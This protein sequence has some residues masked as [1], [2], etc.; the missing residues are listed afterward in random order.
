MISPSADRDP[1]LSVVVPVYN[2][3]GRFQILA[4][5]VA[6][7]LVGYDF[8]LILVNDGSVDGSWHEIVAI[9][10]NPRIRGIDLMRNYGQHNAL[11]AGIR[12]AEKQMIVTIDDDLQ[13]PPE[14]IPRLVDALS[15]ADLVYG[16]PVERQHGRFRNLG[17]TLAKVAIQVAV[18]REMARSVSAFRAFRT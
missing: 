17:T 12:A 4:D 15:H 6:A 7:A 1:G 13:N 5:R 18:G 2:A 3:E 11:L 8:E 10:E 9:S 16:V 14:E